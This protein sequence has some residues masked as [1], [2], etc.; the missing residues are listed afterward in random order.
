MLADEIS[1]DQ[2]LPS[3]YPGLDLIQKQIAAAQKFNLAHD[4]ALAADGLCD[5]FHELEKIAPFCRLPYPVCWFE[6]AQADRAHWMNAPLHYPG[7]Q[8]APHRI[9]FLTEAIGG[10]LAHWRTYLCWSLK[11]YPAGTGFNISPITVIYDTKQPLVNDLGD[12]IEFGLAPFDLDLPPDLQKAYLTTLAQSDWA[13]EIRYLFAILGLLNSRN[14]T[15]TERVEYGK[16]NKQR[17]KHKKHLL[18]AHTLLKIRPTHKPSLIGAAGVARSG[19]IRAHFCRGH[20][21][22]RKTGVFWWG[23]HMRGRLEHGFISKDYEVI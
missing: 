13:G 21:K 20:F 10:D 6:V 18:S 16:L 22:T 11:D 7:L 4:F 14:A 8:G 19:E 1:S 3:L 23:P 9:G 5:N 2:I 12:C 17:I 15:E